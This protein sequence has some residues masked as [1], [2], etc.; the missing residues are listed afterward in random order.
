MVAG[1]K[2]VLAAVKHGRTAHG[3]QHRG[4]RCRAISP[5][6]PISRCRPSG[7][8]APSPA[9][10]RGAQTYF[11]DATRLR[12]RAVRASRIGANMFM[13]GLRLSARR[14]AAV[15]RR[16]RD[17]DRAQRRGGGDE[18]LR[19]SAGAAAPRSIRPRSRRWCS[20][21]R[22]SHR[23]ARILS[24]SFDEMVARRVAFSPTIRIAAYA[25][26]YKAMV[27]QGVGRR[28]LACAGKS[29]LPRRSRAT[30]SS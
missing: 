13:R 19:R 28:G 14:D 12:D 27:A 17:G 15:G 18:S 25:A 1:N 16:D 7:S 23:S 21:R 6:T 30:C 26:R 10:R 29:G 3:D 4:V 11:I 22:N 24:Q 20:R 8:S 9:R 5:A 2:K